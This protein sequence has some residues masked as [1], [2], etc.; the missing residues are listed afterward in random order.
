MKSLE[1]QPRNDP[2]RLKSWPL[3]QLGLPGGVSAVTVA[4]NLLSHHVLTS[5]Y[6]SCFRIVKVLGWLSM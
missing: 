2:P 6:H 1:N 4:Q 3:K 5:R